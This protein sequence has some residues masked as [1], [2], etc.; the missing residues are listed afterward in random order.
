MPV[1]ESE[2]PRST[3]SAFRDTGRASGG[4]TGRVTRFDHS[5][6]LPFGPVART[7]STISLPTQSAAGISRFSGPGA[8]AGTSKLFAEAAHASREKGLPPGP[9][10]SST[11]RTL[12]S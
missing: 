10:R 3:F 4:V 12:M 8:L 7:A 11:E 9:A 1:Q 6:G 2:T 5:D